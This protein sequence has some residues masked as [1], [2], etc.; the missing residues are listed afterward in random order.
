MNTRKIFCCL[1]PFII[2]LNLTA[3]NF[4]DN[5]PDLQIIEYYSTA[6]DNIVIRNNSSSPDTWTVYAYKYGHFNSTSITSSEEGWYQ[7]AKA[8]ILKSNQKYKTSTV[9]KGCFKDTDYYAIK[10]ESGNE[11]DYKIEEHHNDFYLYIYDKG[12]LPSK[13]HWEGFN[14]F[15]IIISIV[16]SVVLIVP[17]ITFLSFTGSWRPL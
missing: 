2:K 12:K 15:P 17:F 16:I 10:A 7:I 14:K 6:E 8:R 5:F 13:R 11:Y 4:T 9:W 1:I 3:E